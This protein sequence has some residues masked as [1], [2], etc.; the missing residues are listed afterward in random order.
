M[1]IAGSPALPAT[2]PAPCRDT[3]Q[4]R[5]GRRCHPRQ[6]AG[7]DLPDP[8]RIDLVVGMTNTFPNALTAGHGSP[9]ASSSACD[10]S[11]VAAR[12]AGQAGRA[13]AVHPGLRTHARAAGAQTA[14]VTISLPCSRIALCP[15]RAPTA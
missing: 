5:I 7:R 15:V 8:R 6:I 12:L 1:M 11:F 13:G 2:A 14:Q 10:P 9:S 3:L 4:R